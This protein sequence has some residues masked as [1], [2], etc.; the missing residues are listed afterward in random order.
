MKSRLFLA[1]TLLTS[2]FLGSRAEA[3]TV[4][5]DE[6]KGVAVNVGAL[7]QPWFQMTAP[8]GKGEGSPGVG[9][10]DGKSPSWDFFMRRARI[11]VYG[12]ITK[13]L[14]YFVETDQPNLG[15]GGDW[16][17]PMFV[18]DAFFSYTFMP[19][20]KVDVGMMLVP[21]SHH[22]LE[23]ATG[24][25]ALDYH[26]DTIRFP[27]GKVFRDT[28]IQLRGLA[29]NN[30]LHYRLGV[31]EGVRAGAVPAPTAMGTAGAEPLNSK[32]LPRF[33]A[34]L[35]FNIMGEEADFFLK[36]IYFSPKPLISVG[37]GAD[38]QPN[39]VRKVN[40]EPGLYRALSLDA[41]VEYPFT[42][43]DELIFKG[44]VFNYGEG[45]AVNVNQDTT[46]GL[47]T[48]ATGALPGSTALRT[49]GTAFYAE[50][51]FRHAWIE[52]LAFIDYVK[53]KDDALT[54]LAPHVG[55]N[56]WINK[57][58]YNIKVDVGYKKTETLTPATANAAAV[59][60][61][62]KDILGTV[63]GQVFF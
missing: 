7:L 38:I 39:G 16:N 50:A 52:P 33:A 56:F 44:N 54:I 2:M 49:G 37:I 20:L 40:N 60:A 18:Q 58:T 34:Q 41:F 22:T 45:A 36:G 53:A 5:K 8:D 15:K 29:A 14:A 48:T 46:T 51:G 12:N 13:D 17:Q 24:L 42:A 62:T 63:Q 21:L 3:A 47:F 32:G 11:L 6:E 4:F 19:E 1:T 27:A 61:T 55:C 28:G 59:L 30:L 31:F 9:A 10:P 43:D 26:A 25:N 57:H 35:R 23:G